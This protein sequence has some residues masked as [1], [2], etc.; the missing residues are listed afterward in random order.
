MSIYVRIDGLFADVDYDYGVSV[1]ATMADLRNGV[2]VR[3]A[4]VT[5]D[6]IIDGDEWVAWHGSPRLFVVRGLPGAGKSTLAA[7][8]PGSPV[9]VAADDYFVV[10]GGAYR[11]DARHVHAAHADC[12][13]RCREALDALVD[14][15][16]VGL[17]GRSVAVANT[18]CKAWEAEPYFALAKAAGVPVVVV[19]VFDGGLDDEQ[20]A[21]RNVHGVPVAAIAGMRARWE[22]SIWGSKCSS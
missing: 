7:Q 6:Y 5:A 10:D 8:L 4:D 12:Q 2:W 18:F 13:R 15:A 17:V 16:G 1:A 21:A 11:F 22:P 3:D 20:L 19:D 9:V 14:V